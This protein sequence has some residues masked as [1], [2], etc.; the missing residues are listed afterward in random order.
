VRQRLAV[1]VALI[2]G[3]ALVGIL[4]TRSSPA[5]PVPA[6]RDRVAAGI[7]F[8]QTRWVQ[9]P[10]DYPAGRQLVGRYVA[11]FG[12]A[13][14]LG[15]IAR[16]ES[17]AV[18][19]LGVEPDRPAAWSRLSGLFLMQHRFREA[20]VAAD[21]ALALDPTHIEA[22]GAA[23][24]AALARGDYAEAEDLLRRLPGGEVATLV[25]WAAFLD[26][27]GRS[28]EAAILQ[29]RACGA[30]ERGSAPT[31]ARA[32][33]LTQLAGMEL[34]TRGAPAAEARLQEA[35]RVQPRYRGAIE[36]LAGLAA[37]E[38]RWER[39]ARLYE[40]VATEAHPDLF[41]RLAEVAD[42]RRD[43]TGAAAWLRRF[44][45]A[46]LGPEREA[47]YGPSVAHYH[48]ER[49][50]IEEGLVV[51]RREVARRPTVESWDLLAWAL[52]RAG[53]HAEALEASDR[54]RAWGVPGPT[55][56]FTRGRILQALGQEVEGERFL[57]RAREGW[58][59]L[60]PHARRAAAGGP[61]PP[62]GGWLARRATD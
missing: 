36:R 29:A 26:L 21:S 4:L 2:G 45:A 37:A 40:S 43:T 16:A 5:G 58:F 53:R 55:L 10:R 18:A 30:L 52:Y 24:D 7:A 57:T 20:A 62:Q 49:G 12:L 35:L 47:L 3:A 31:L 23:A 39:A 41:L 54:A 9:D 60:A 19:L 6:T 15:D 28:S 46:A 50:R 8:F 38:Q 11:R 32:W 51:A 48:L 44:E 25:R 1:G 13:A 22:T 33:C 34:S 27:A 17:V 59:Q 56:D 42:A 61:A 14:D